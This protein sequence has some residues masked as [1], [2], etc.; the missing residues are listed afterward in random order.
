M[1]KY[2]IK[3]QNVLYNNKYETRSIIT[4]FTVVKK[5]CNYVHFTPSELNNIDYFKL[6][7]A[8]YFK[9]MLEIKRFVRKFPVWRMILNRSIMISS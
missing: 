9:K 1:T 8:N 2:K 4:Y 5:H 3:G 6:F 7:S